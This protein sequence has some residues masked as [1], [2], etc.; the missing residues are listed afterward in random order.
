MCLLDGSK[1]SLNDKPIRGCQ[2]V[3][4]LLEGGPNSA[5]TVYTSLQNSVACVI[6]AKSGRAADIIAY[7]K[8]NCKYRKY[9]GIKRT[10]D[11][12]T[13]FIQ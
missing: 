8:E 4:I 1:S 3:C 13:L 9:V 12:L 6:A 5:L 10:P 11:K 2:A 7:A